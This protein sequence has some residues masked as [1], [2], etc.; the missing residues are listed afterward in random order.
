MAKKLLRLSEVLELTGLTRST[1][2]RLIDEGKFPSQVSLTDGRL[3][4]W[5]CEEVHAWI[6]QRIAERDG[7]HMKS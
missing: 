7:G 3:V 4:A 1:C 2:Y 5:V 6:D